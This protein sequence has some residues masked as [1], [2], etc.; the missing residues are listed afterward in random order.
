MTGGAKDELV[1]DWDDGKEEE[2]DE[3]GEPTKPLEMKPAPTSEPQD[4]PQSECW[5]RGHVVPARADTPRMPHS[6][7]V[8]Y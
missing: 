3:D 5:R 2:D 8:E 6:W 1:L 7:S 4:Q